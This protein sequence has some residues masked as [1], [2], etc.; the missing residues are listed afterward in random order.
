MM[1]RAPC[2]DRAPTVPGAWVYGTMPPCPALYRA[3]AWGTV[4]TALMVH[5]PCPPPAG[6]R[7]YP[8]HR[9]PDTFVENGRLGLRN[10]A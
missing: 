9:E 6:S 3:R 7:H 10:P 8:D 4:K 2:P 1:D 5:L